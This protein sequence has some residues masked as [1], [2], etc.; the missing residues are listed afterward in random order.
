MALIVDITHPPTLSV[1]KTMISLIQQGSHRRLKVKGAEK[2]NSSI[3]VEIPE[4]SQVL[5]DFCGCK[6]AF[7][8]KSVGAAAPTL[9]RPLWY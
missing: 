8:K 7:L 1:L 2:P 4:Y 6:T 5:M 9:T 3:C